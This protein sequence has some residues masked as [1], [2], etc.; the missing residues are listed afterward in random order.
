MYTRLLLS[1]ILTVAT[2]ASGICQSV[3]A[4]YHKALFLHPEDGPFIETYLAINGNSIVYK[5]NED[6][7]L[8]GKVEVTLIFL[9]NDSIKF[10]DK[11]EI[12]S[13]IIADEKTPKSSFL[14]IQR[15]PLPNGVYHFEMQIKDLNGEGKTTASS[16]KDVVVVDFNE[17][18]VSIS[19]I[20][21]VES[22]ERVEERSNFVKGGVKLI[23][24]FSTF[25]P[26]HKE[27]MIFY[28]EIYN[29]VK[30][31]G[32][33]YGF[34]VNYYIESQD[35]E[36]KLDKYSKFK[37][38]VAKE[39]N[40]LFNQFSIADLP[41]GNYN[42]VVEI[43][44]RSNGLLVKKKLFF[45]RSNP[46]L[47]IKPENLA[48]LDL[49]RSFVMNIPA[50]SLAE[51]I[52]SC[53]P[54]SSGN[55]RSYAQTQ[56]AVGDADLMRRYLQHFWEKRSTLEPES[57]WLAYSEQVRKVQKEYGRMILKGYETDRGRVY[58][59][60]GLPNSI[61]VRNMDPA[62]YPYEIWHY[63]KLENVSNAKFIF[64]NPELADQNYD[65]LHSN[66]R[67]EPSDPAWRYK[68]QNLRPRTVDEL[69]DPNSFDNRASD[70]WT[71][72]K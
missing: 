24:Y 12:K 15:I 65:L 45:Q 27:T 20:E 14:D 62:S 10:F 51:C 18:Q 9:K 7:E 71:H 40:V 21:L 59:Q 50:D 37:K 39:A 1:I 13:P 36:L 2:L 38:E 48:N 33:E 4:Y 41:S 69:L 5:A 57:L 34:L 55:E 61:E 67:G 52:R 53:S 43:K 6:G 42:L 70:F 8:Q 64:Y 31:L 54:I 72:P 26:E 46:N 23:P 32:A 16:Y 68:L 63:Y 25:Y 29:C 44:D 58:L 17:A 28:A 19:D 47:P 60:Y 35:A 3:E 11:F 22:F 49:S 66:V 30:V 56:L